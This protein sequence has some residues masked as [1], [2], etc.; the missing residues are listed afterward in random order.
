MNKIAVFILLIAL[1]FVI[2]STEVIAS[3]TDYI[4]LNKLGFKLLEDNE[5]ARA[6]KCFKKAIKLNDNYTV[7]YNNLGS[8]FYRINNY[9]KAIYYFKKVIEKEQYYVKAY[10]NLAGSYF[11][12]NE[13][14]KAYKYYHKAV[15]ID[16]KYVKK[17]FDNKQTEDK[18]K[19]TVEDKKTNKALQIYRNEM[20]ELD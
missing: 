13:Y 16:K 4:L 15:N 12:K 20:K 17:R 18:L 6:I 14:L 3:N 5:I 19:N 11:Q 9:D 7:A 1:L 2:S 8:A 10:T